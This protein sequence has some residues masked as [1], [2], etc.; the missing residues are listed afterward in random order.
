[1]KHLKCQKHLSIKLMFY[2]LSFPDLFHIYSYLIGLPQG[3]LLCLK[4]SFKSNLF[5]KKD[6]DLKMVHCRISFT[7][8]AFVKKMLA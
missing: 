2:P 5:V 1:M 4:D 6:T 3:S 7:R 8:K